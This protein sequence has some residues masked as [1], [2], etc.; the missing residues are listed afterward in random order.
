MGVAR[1]VRA[2]ANE[3]EELAGPARRNIDQSAGELSIGQER[4][5][6]IDRVK[7]GCIGL[8]PLDAVHGACADRGQVGERA[9]EHRGLCAEGGADNDRMAALGK[10][11]G[12]ASGCARCV[13]GEGAASGEGG[14]DR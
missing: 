4:G 1:E 8:L 5:G 7:D 3:D 10:P 11:P 2:R 14:C 6:G 12:H 9:L 13:Y